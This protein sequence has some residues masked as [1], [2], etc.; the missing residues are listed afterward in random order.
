TLIDGGYHMVYKHLF[1]LS[2]Q[3]RPQWVTAD[4][5]QLGVDPQGR[6]IAELGEDFVSFTVGFE[7][8]LRIV[9]AHAWTLAADPLRPR[10]TFLAGT[11][12]TLDVSDDDPAV[13][14]LHRAGQ[15]EVVDLAA[16]P[17]G[18]AQRMQDCLLDYLDALAHDRP[19]QHGSL[20][21][22]RQTLQIILGVYES[23]RT[24]QRV[25]VG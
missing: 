9:S 21:L 17:R 15:W 1:W 7:G 10:Q 8:P 22:A 19:P 24:G 2:S 25:M 6:T 3:G 20:Q 18:R 11:E 14:G 23:A 13:L 12:A 5:A 16:P 4:A